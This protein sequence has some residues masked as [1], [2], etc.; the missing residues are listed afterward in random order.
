M[1]DFI[2]VYDDVL[3]RDFCQ[4]LIQLFEQSPH[5]TAGRTGGGVDTS[6]KLSTDLYLNQHPEYHAALNE[7]CRFTTDY[8][9]RYF[10]KYHFA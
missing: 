10:A 7:I 3:P 1:N 8:V 9:V 5:T 2:E 4:Q 6:K